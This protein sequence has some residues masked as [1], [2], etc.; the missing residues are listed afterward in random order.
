MCELIQERGVCNEILSI[1]NYMTVSRAV[2][3]NVVNQDWYVEKELT[4]VIYD[5]K[6][7]VCDE[8]ELK[9]VSY[10]Y[11]FSLKIVLIKN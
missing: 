11:M 7:W 6:C 1:Y 4:K 9:E 10:M 2:I 5:Q 3:F 8:N